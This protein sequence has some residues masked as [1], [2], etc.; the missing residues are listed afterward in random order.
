ME[1]N[2]LAAGATIA[3][4]GHGAS[5]ARTPDTFTVLVEDS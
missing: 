5:T 2:L 4:G 3:A 1:W